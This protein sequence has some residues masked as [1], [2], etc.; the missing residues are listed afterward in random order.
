MKKIL[1][2]FL[3]AL[4]AVVTASAQITFEWGTAKWNIE[5]G[6]KYASI[7]D[8]ESDPLT[9]SYPNPA[10]FTFTFLNMIAVE[11]NIYVDNNTEPIVFSSSDRGCDIIIDYKFPEGHTYKIVT[12]KSQLAQANLATFVTDT[13]STSL[14]SYSISFSIDGP[15]I[16]K[17]IDVE[18]KMS[19]AI[20]DQEWTPTFSVIDTKDICSCLGINSIDDAYVVGLNVNGSYSPYYLLTFD[21]WRDADGEVTNWNGGW[22]NYFG[23]NCYPAVYSIKLNETADT[24]SYFFYDYWRDYNP[25][26]GETTEGGTITTGKLRAPTT[27]YNDT[28]WDWVNEDGTITKY[29]RNWR[30]EVGKD[31]KA[32]FMYIANKKAVK[33]NA[34]MHFVSEKE[35]EEYLNE[36]TEVKAVRVMDDSEDEI[37]SLNGVRQAELRKGINI[38]KSNGKVV[39]ILK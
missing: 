18:S 33:L 19:I 31:Y 39:K 9:L 14:D 4:C 10:G 29:K 27:V 32:S 37:Y 38:V 3:V 2:T 15:E 23:H 34:T 12:T 26:E 6:K 7:D 36:I 20:L 21:G 1:L 5:D 30:C 11:Y 16:V 25:E 24:V 17:T 8:Y 22:N 35:Y 28:I 13:L